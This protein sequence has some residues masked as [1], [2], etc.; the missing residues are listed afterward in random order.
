MGD[1]Y[2]TARLTL[3]GDR[4]EILVRPEAAFEFK[5]GKSLNILKLL[6]VDTIFTDASKGLRASEESLQKV[7]HSTDV[8]I[9]AEKILRRGE[10]QLTITQRRKL[11]EEKR[12]Q[13]ITFISRNCVDLGGRRIIKKQR[14]K[15]AMEQ[16]RV[17][18]D[19]FVDG[20]EQARSVIDTLRPILPLKIEQISLAVKVPPEYAAQT[21]GMARSFA[22][23]QRGEWQK[24]GSWIGIIEISAGLHTSFLDRIGKV[25][26]GNYQ[27]KILK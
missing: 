23:I 15:Q 11:V 20:E 27:I 26:H 25:T 5:K 16:I 24:D 17:V 8:I 14:I 22:N 12:K 10:L 18:I 7:F 4:F 3:A 6:V 19:P 13:I 9:I 2:T 21:I 1:K